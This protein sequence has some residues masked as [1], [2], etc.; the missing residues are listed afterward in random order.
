MT[1]KGRLFRPLAVVIVLLFFSAM[2]IAAVSETVPAFG[3]DTVL[4]WNIRNAGLEAGF[5]VRLAS[6]TPD[7]YLEWENEKS[8]GTVFIPR[9]DVQNAKDFITSR[10]FAGGR[11]H[12]TR[13]A[14]T[15]WLS[16]TM[17][18]DL[19]ERKKV[20]YN[21]ESVTTT[22]TFLGEDV[23]M[24]EVNRVPMELP[25]IVV[26]DGRG[27]ERWFLDREEN[28]L[29]VRH[30]FREYDKKL[31][32]ISTERTGTLRWIKGSKLNNQSR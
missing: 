22:Y 27:G 19:K 1:A 11:E 15:L 31:L 16:R 21:L 24:V 8:Q 14:T 2:A 32:S 25:V 28:P 5:V 18:S 6:F 9:Q 10:L 26:S 20:R 4:V 3:R 29:M 7:I 30:R 23:L 17:F 12:R 13:N